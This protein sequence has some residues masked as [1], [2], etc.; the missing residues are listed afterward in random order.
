MQ[1]SIPIPK[2]DKLREGGLDY[3]ADLSTDEYHCFN[4][5][6]NNQATGVNIYVKDGLNIDDINFEVIDRD[7]GVVGY[8]DGSQKLNLYVDGAPAEVKI[9]LN[10]P[11]VK[12]GRDNLAFHITEEFNLSHNRD[13]IKLE[14]FDDTFFFD[15][16][17]A[18]SNDKTRLIIRETDVD[19]LY[20]LD[21]SNVSLEVASSARELVYNNIFSFE[22][23]EATGKRLI[24]SNENFTPFRG[25]KADIIEIKE[26]RVESSGQVAGNYKY[27]ISA[28]EA[29]VNQ[30]V[31]NIERPL[32]AS[33]NIPCGIANIRED[34]K[35][36]LNS[37]V[38]LLADQPLVVDTD[39]FET[40][41][42]SIHIE[43][44]MPE[45]GA[46]DSF[47]A[48]G[49]AIEIRENTYLKLGGTKAIFDRGNNLVEFGGK[50][51]LVK[52]STQILGEHKVLV[53]D[54]TLYDC[55]YEHIKNNGI[56]FTPY[57]LKNV[58]ISNATLVDCSFNPDGHTKIGY[59]GERRD[60]NGSLMRFDNC[61]FKA[62]DNVVTIRGDMSKADE[63]GSIL[64]KNIV[65]EGENAL[66]SLPLYAESTIKSSLVK[67]GTLVVGNEDGKKYELENLK[68]SGE[69]KIL[70]NEAKI[71]ETEFAGTTLI[72]SPKIDMEFCFTKDANILGYE[73]VSNL[74]LFNKT[75]QS[76]GESELKINTEFLNSI[77]GIEKE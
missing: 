41:G 64:F 59:Q 18:S 19:N 72:E 37:D 27:A 62:E 74:G 51:D 30:A 39:R 47:I 40:K 3:R 60:F 34:G 32:E 75:F 43:T 5:L 31:I 49:D 20:L 12:E 21:N 33:N 16:F 71:K 10:Y 45:N 2:I 14:S 48:A 24:I 55:H 28:K 54:T 58:D 23:E 11:I 77:N 76:K 22:N 57:E 50:C 52:S 69:T 66:V 7:I 73:K 46:I 36:L 26:L 68:S 53:E 70:T 35:I 6:S 4:I 15:K 42:N 17:V 63:K 65:T 38:Y 1:T 29:R 56:N 8:R 25:G 67:D 61:D 9:D 13:D 44:T